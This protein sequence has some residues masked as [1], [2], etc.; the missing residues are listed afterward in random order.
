MSIL[1][2]TSSLQDILNQVNALP[3]YVEPLDTSDA[4]ATASD[5]LSGETAYV[6]G[7]KITGTIATKTS[8][9]LSASGATVTVPAGYYA[10]QATKSVSTATQA[11]PSISVDSAGKITASTTQTEG[12]V[13]AGT[14]SS[15]K[16]LTVQAAKTVTPTKSS[17]TAVASGV[18]TTGTITVGAIP[19][20]YITTTDAT[21]EASEIFSGETAYVNGS[22]VTG[23]FTVEDEVA[24]QEELIP[25][26]LAALEGKAGESGGSS[27]SGSV[28]TCTVT[29]DTDVPVPEEPIIVCV[30]EDGAQIN[31]GFGQYTVRKDN[32]ITIYNWGNSDGS[33]GASGDNCTFLYYYQGSASFYISG[34]CSITYT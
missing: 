2:N 19:D 30:D 15:T 32:I 1:T 13:S 3:D 23:T 7:E 18:Y 17:Q 20:E 8:S 12:Y 4:T 28:E 6:N 33:G 26:I 10:S 16:Q 29:L 14:K 22:K 24:T 25:Q 31:S 5:I 27:G 11:T 9:N 21:A 34:D